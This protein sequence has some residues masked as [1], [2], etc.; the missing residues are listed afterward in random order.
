MIALALS[1][2]TEFFFLFFIFVKRDLH[3]M[4]IIPF[5]FFFFLVPCQGDFW[6]YIYKQV[7]M[8]ENRSLSRCDSK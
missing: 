6:P 3:N 2:Y 4:Y 7:Y 5:F 8:L 1:I